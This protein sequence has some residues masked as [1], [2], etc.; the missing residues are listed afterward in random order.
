MQQV[1]LKWFMAAILDMFICVFL[2]L[3]GNSQHNFAELADV[4][5]A[6]DERFNP[7]RAV[8]EGGR[9]VTEELESKLLVL[10]EQMRTVQQQTA[11]KHY[12]K[13][14]KK[15]I[16]MVLCS[17]IFYSQCSMKFSPH[18][19]KTGQ[20]IDSLQDVKHLKGTWKV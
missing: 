2:F 20:S 8:A 13:K 5:K 11:Q 12:G 17:V 4:K 18:Q 7:C 1:H 16:W 15:Q 3:Q 9:D 10:S 19:M 6:T 14:K